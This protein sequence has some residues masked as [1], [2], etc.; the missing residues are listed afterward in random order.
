MTPKL[1]CHRL[2]WLALLGLGAVAAFNLLVDPIGAYRAFSLRRFS[3]FRQT[4][5][6]RT[7]RA[8]LARRGPWD[9]IVLGTSRPKAGLPA[10]HPA[11]AT[12]RVCNLAI[13]GGR[14]SEAVAILEFAR[15]HQP[16]RRVALFLD[17]VMFSSTNLYRH[18]F[19]QSRFNPR[20]ARFEYHCRNLVGAD[21]TAH[22]WQFLVKSLHHFQP[23][24]GET[25]GF[26]VH[27]IRART[28]QR[29]LF[30]RVLAS[31]AAAYAAMRA[32]PVQMD[33]LRHVLR[34]CR[35]ANIDLVLAINP[36]HAL[37]LELL[38][39]GG[40]WGR[41]EQWKREIVALTAS[42]NPAVPL[43]D[44]SGYDRFTTEAVPPRGSPERMKFYFENSHYTPVLGGLMLDR[45]FCGAATE[46]GSILS[47]ENIEPHLRRI[48]QDR[49]RYAHSH[50]AEVE[51]V[52][53]IAARSQNQSSE[54]E[55]DVE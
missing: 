27:A 15:A 4:L 41:F 47:R 20:L 49:E 30:E 16:L 33:Q 22:S 32:A 2:L 48:R 12:N 51:W 54:T 28:S 11:F 6:T 36:V 31:H 14:M 42:E 18:D 45:I 53:A 26:Y 50:A 34:V 7:S 10:L 43:W 46:F 44:F 55:E 52:Q 35:E 38:R 21:M 17:F 39:A 23:P 3:A 37:D 9:M 24:P 19:A 8:E 5:F 29:D 13:D 1:Y 25:N 40:N